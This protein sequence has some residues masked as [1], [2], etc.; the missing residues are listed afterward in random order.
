MRLWTI[1]PPEVVDIINTTE[2]FTCD[3]TL[4]ENYKDFHDAYHW[5]V[6]EMDKR[7][8][9]H[10]QHLTLP[11]WAWHT[12]N[13]KHKKP[14]FRYMG[15]GVRG[16]RYACIEFEIPDNQVLL[17][18]YDK[19]HNVLNKSW[20]DDSTNESEFDELQAWF[21]TLEPQERHKLTIDS[22]QKIFDTTYRK[23]QWDSNG[24]YIQA[25][26]WVLEKSMIRDIKYFIAK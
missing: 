18:D 1:Q 17:S 10:P 24:E 26:F 15:L 19:W 22:W 8:I 25:T 7:N 14:D 20:Y 3:T 13:A 9:T 6:N 23:S 5:L 11:L 4:S 21:D 12:R 2:Q 16:T